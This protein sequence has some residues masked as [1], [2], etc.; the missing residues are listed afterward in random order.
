MEKHNFL[1]FFQNEQDLTAVMEPYEI[2][3]RFYMEMTEERSKRLTGKSFIPKGLYECVMI[4]SQSVSL[5]PV[6][7]NGEYYDDG[8]ASIQ[9]LLLEN[10]TIYGFSSLNINRRMIALL[11]D[12][13]QP[14]CIISKLKG[15]N[16]WD[17]MREFFYALFRANMNYV[18]LRKF[19]LLP[20]SFVEGD[21]DIDV[22]CKT[23]DDFIS[24]VGAIKR[25]GGVSSY[26]VEING[27]WT[28]LD[29]RFQGD[30]YLPNAWESEILA[31][32]IYNEKNIS[33]MNKTNMFFSVLYHIFTQ[34]KEIA[35]YYRKFIQDSDDIPVNNRSKANDEDYL[36]ALISFMRFNGYTFVRP[37]DQSVVQNQRNVKR[38]KAALFSIKPSHKIVI[39]IYRMLPRII[40]YLLPESLKNRVFNLL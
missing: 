4:S 28:D 25:S 15:E 40:V 19:E 1:L 30:N 31:S 18:V 3:N 13:I 38:I 22:L 17:D 6:F 2:I 10:E 16:G 23:R 26:K 11:P 27:V 21:H 14:D 37:A 9:R 7:E 20:D 8:E 24:F 12:S 32:R 29:V 33:V 36:N 5:G 35:D 39:G 34:K